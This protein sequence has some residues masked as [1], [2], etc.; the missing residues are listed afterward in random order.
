MKEGKE[1]KYSFMSFSTPNLTLPE[2][3]ATAKRFKYDGVE[4]R[5]DANH[6]HG[7][8]VSTSGAKRCEVKKQTVSSGISI[9]CVATSCVYANAETSEQNVDYTLKCID[10]AADVGSSILRVFGG[11]IDECISREEAICLVGR[12]LVYVTDYAS[13]RGVT[14]CMETHDDWCDP[15]DVAEVMKQV[16]HSSIGVDWD[17]M[18]PVRAGFATM[19]QAFQTLKP[20]IKHVHVHDAQPGTT[21]P[22]PIGTGGYN[23]RRVIQLLLTIPY[24]GYLS[25]EWIG[26]KDPYDLHLPRELAT[27]KKY[28]AELTTH[29][30]E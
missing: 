22:V 7:V 16:S 18:H 17:V 5:I 10:L 4:L 15:K 28:E 9:S 30:R 21:K 12:S 14:V 25:G 29:T 6:K 2:M 8:E 11:K 13:Q 27:L 23:H 3:L 1:L 24:E 19:D 26:W 20:W